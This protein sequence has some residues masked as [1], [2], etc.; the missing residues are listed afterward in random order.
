MLFLFFQGLATGEFPIVEL[1]VNLLLIPVGS[2]GIPEFSV[3][4]T[5]SV[6]RVFKTLFVLPPLFLDLLDP[7]L[8]ACMC[9]HIPVSRLVAA[10]VATPCPP[11]CCGREARAIG[12]LSL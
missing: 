3:S 9:A 11:A 4:I 1:C 10:L 6:T 12:L 2:F 5:I 7:L 8:S